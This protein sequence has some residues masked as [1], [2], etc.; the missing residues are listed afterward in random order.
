VEELV[1]VEEDVG[2]E[3]LAMVVEAIELGERPSRWE[4]VQAPWALC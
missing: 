4:W 3:E 1:V 2:V